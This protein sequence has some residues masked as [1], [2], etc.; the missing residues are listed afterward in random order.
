[1]L[2]HH[3]S[4]EGS[5]VHSLRQWGAGSRCSAEF[6]CDKDETAICPMDEDKGWHDCS[7]GA[8]STGFGKSFTFRSATSGTLRHDVADVALP[9]SLLRLVLFQHLNQPRL[10]CTLTARIHMKVLMYSHCFCQW[11]Q[12]YSSRLCLIST[13]RFNDRLQC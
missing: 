10:R 5:D 9:T 13:G 6:T 8:D 4:W 12:T 1:M 7:L 2:S 3:Y 11:L